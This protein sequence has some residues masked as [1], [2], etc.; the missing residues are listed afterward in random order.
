MVIRQLIDQTDI[1]A[2]LE[3]DRAWAAF[4]LADL[5]PGPAARST[6]F[7]PATGNSVV[8]VY[9]AYNV[10]IVIGHGEMDGCDRTLRDP[11]VVRKTAVAHLNVL[12]AWLPMIDRQFSRFDRREMVRMLL[13]VEALASS[14]PSRAERLGP[15]DLADVQMLYAEDPPA[16]FLPAQLGDGVYYGVRDGGDLVAIAGTHVVS[17]AGGVGALGNVHTRSDRRREGLAADVASAVT[18]ELVR[19]GISTIVL[20]IVATNETARRVYERIGFREYC[21]YYEGMAER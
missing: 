7:G 15:S 20:N 9:G 6:W 12:P 1:R 18:G 16:F 5:D 4:S 17:D 11:A 19:R 10:P 13:D 8:L 21:V 14:S 3:H 2:R